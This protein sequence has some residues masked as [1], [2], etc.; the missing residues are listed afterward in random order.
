MA[1]VIGASG[2]YLAHGRAPGAD[3]GPQP[4]DAG[5]DA[6]P[7]PPDAGR[8][9]GPRPRDAGP[10]GGSVWTLEPREASVGFPHEVGCTQVSGGSLAIRVSSPLHSECEHAGPVE[11]E[12]RADG[13]LVVRAFV[14]VEHRPSTDACAPLAARTRRTVLVAA[15]GGRAR[16]EDALSGASAELTVPLVEGG[17]CAGSAERGEECVRD[18]DCRGAMRCVPDLG[19]FAECFGGRCGD[20]CDELGGSAAPVYPRHLDCPFAHECR[21]EGGASGSCVLSADLCRSDAECGPGLSC[22]IRDRMDCEWSVRLSSSTRRP[23]DG[24]DDCEGGMYCVEH[25]GGA[26]R[27]EVPCFTNEMRCPLMH[28]CMPSAGWV[29]EW[30]GE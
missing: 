15:R 28:A 6:R 20:P 17:P 30:L 5:R 1:L 22:P 23:C 11:V 18:C 10:R 9:T 14:W 12:E 13:T 26:R 19:D 25:A 8:D 3:S 21:Q 29:C 7:R 4:R 24:D 2:C 16:V 27:C